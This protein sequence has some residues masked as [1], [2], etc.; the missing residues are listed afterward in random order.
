MYGNCYFRVECNCYFR[1]EC[2]V[3]AND[4]TVKGG[5]YY[6]VTVKKHL[7]A[8]EIARENHLPCVYLGKMP[9]LSLVIRPILTSYL[10]IIHFHKVGKVTARYILLFDWFIYLFSFYVKFDLTLNN[11]PFLKQNVINLGNVITAD[12]FCTWKWCLYS[13]LRNF[14]CLWMFFF[15]KNLLTDI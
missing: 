4:P 12:Y 6:P 5:T 15:T 14:T 9:S 13:M 2:M 7:R 3:V 11:W 8:Q 10:F 1:V